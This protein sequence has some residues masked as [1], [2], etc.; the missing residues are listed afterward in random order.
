MEIQ[1]IYL[2]IN[3]KI[4]INYKYFFS[5]K[6]DRQHIVCLFN[7]QPLEMWLKNQVEVF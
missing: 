7:F 5:L 6:K 2:K 1:L 3:K 4:K